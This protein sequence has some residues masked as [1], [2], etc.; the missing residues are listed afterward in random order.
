[1]PARL[2]ACLPACLQPHVAKEKLAFGA[3]TTDHMLE[4]DWTS[5][6]GWAAPKISAYKPLSIDPAASCLHYG[7]EAFEG[8]KAYLDPQGKAR[9]FRPDL[10]MIR[11]NNSMARLALPP[12]DKEGFLECIKELVRKEK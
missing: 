8:M 6:D 9:L 1:V 3:V 12:L 10:N 7:L 5:K 2:P 11:L 4:V